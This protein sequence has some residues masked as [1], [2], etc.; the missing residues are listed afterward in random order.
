MLDVGDGTTSPV[1]AIG[2]VAIGISDGLAAGGNTPICTIGA[3]VGF[4]VGR[5]LSDKGVTMAGGCETGDGAGGV[6]AAGTGGA[7]K[8]GTAQSIEMYSGLPGLSDWGSAQLRA[9]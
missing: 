1:W 2:G 9:C 6:T 4:E 8:A 3:A 5:G 7:A